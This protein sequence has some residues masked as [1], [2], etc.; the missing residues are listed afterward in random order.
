[1]GLTLALLVLRIR[2]KTIQALLAPDKLAIN[3]HLF[4][5]SA[6][7]H[8]WELVPVRNAAAGTIGAQFKSDSIA[9]DYL[10]IVNLAHFTR[11]VRKHLFA[12]FQFNFEVGI[13]QGL[14]DCSGNFFFNLVDHAERAN[15]K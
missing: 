13:R 9:D 14:N 12:I 15:K 11:Q 3:T 8:V 2:A 4:Y 6:Y 7:F 1:M 10:Y 5:R